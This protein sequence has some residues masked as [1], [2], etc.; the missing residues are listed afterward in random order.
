MRP[1]VRVGDELDV[2]AGRV[3]GYLFVVVRHVGLDEQR[4]H[5]EGCK[6]E[7]QESPAWHVPPCL[8]IVTMTRLIYYNIKNANINQT[9]R[10]CLDGTRLYKLDWQP[11]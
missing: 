5:E 10:L 3:D 6:H 4:S 11:F 8:S 7:G 9:R 1:W 2:D